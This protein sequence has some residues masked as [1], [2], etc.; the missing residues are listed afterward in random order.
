MFCLLVDDFG[1]EYVGERHNIHLKQDLSKHYELTDKWKGDL[2]SGIN[3]EWNY[4]TIHAN[5]TVRL[6]MDDYIANL[7]VK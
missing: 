5:S 4:D 7:R 1:V 6:T 2:Y 3:I